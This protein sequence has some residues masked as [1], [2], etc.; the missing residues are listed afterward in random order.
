SQT[1][2][3]FEL[4]IVDDGSADATITKMAEYTGKGI[5]YIRIKH[6][7]VSGARNRAIQIAK[8]E[9]TA[10]LDSDDRWDRQ[11]LE[12]TRYYIKKFPDINI[13][14][15]DEIWYKNNKFLNQKKKHR[16]PSGYIYPNCLKLCCVG[17]STSVVKS[18]IF[19]EIGFFDENLPACEDYD[20]WLRACCKYKVKLIPEALTI[21][22]GG[23]KDQLSNQPGLDKYRI[24]ALKK[25]IESGL[26]NDEQS[27]ITC[28]EL[29]NKCRI[30][31][32]GA[33]KR[34][35]VKEAQ[36]YIQ[37]AEKYKI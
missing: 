16:R 34:G 25:I 35:K 31:A 37:L 30:Y 7:G 17:M 6:N 24:Y 26:L 27:A 10:F 15:T 14:H 2:S 3:D 5:N 33:L 21:K 12:K 9:Y 19:D 32:G 1:F 36:N 11:K 22:S 20:L 13:F 8:G 23:R 4:I 29:I 28:F 18:E